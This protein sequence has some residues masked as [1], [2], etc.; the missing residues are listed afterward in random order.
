MRSLVVLLSILLMVSCSQEH[1]ERVLMVLKTLDNPFFQD[2]QQ[3]ALNEWNRS[4]S[5]IEFSVKAGQ[6]EGDVEGQRRILDGAFESSVAQTRSLLKGVILTPSGS[7]SDLIPQI[8][9]LRDVGIPIV[10]LDTGINVDMLRK[11]ETNY[12]T[13]IRSDNEAGGRLAASALVNGLQSRNSCRLLILNGV[14]DHDTAKA[15]RDGFVAGVRGTGCE[16]VLEKSGNWRRSEAQQIVGQLTPNWNFDG[17]FAANDEMALGVHAALNQANVGG[18]TLIV[19]FDAIDEA[20]SAVKSGILFATVAQDPEEMGK[21]GVRRI[22]QLF[23]ENPT[24]FFE[25]ILLPPRLV[26]KQVEF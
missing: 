2:M 10:L 5:K 1:E 8:K 6:N 20:I 15:R 4:E 9:R 18:N 19:G 26:T 22:K 16:I 21:A 3:G 17:V 24:T 7:G 11:A 23:D 12:N 25:E 13:L 14:P